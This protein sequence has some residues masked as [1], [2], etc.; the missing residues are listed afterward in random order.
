MKSN[1]SSGPR[2]PELHV[3]TIIP[4]GIDQRWGTDLTGTFTAEH[5]QASGLLAVDH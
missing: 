4:E 2:G 3:G 5:G 1:G